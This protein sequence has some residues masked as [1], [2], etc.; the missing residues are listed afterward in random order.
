[1]IGATLDALSLPILNIDDLAQTMMNN[2]KSCV[3][4]VASASCLQ[5]VLPLAKSESWVSKRHSTFSGARGGSWEVLKLSRLP[6]T[7]NTACLDVQRLP[8]LVEDLE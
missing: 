7:W 6:C 1:M 5:L 8:V 2:N 4:Q 3:S